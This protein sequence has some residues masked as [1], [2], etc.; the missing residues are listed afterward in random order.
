[1]RRLGLVSA[2]CACA[3]LQSATAHA[4][5]VELAPDDAPPEQKAF[6]A[7]LDK[8]QWVDGPSTVQLTGNASLQVPEGYVF[9]NPKDT[10]RYLEL[11]QNMGDGDEVLVA[12]A[13]LAWS[14]YLSY[15]DEGYVKDDEE[16]DA[17]AL[18]KTLQE[19]T[20]AG[21]EVRRERGWEE[22]HV[23]G[24]A[25]PPAYNT[26]T[27]RLE[28]AT[29]TRS[30]NGEGVNFFTKI[31]GRK[32]HTS[33]QLVTGPETLAEDQALLDG[34][35]GGFEYD[36]GDRYADFR[37]GDKV[38]EY[39]LAAMVVG[40]AAAVAT[41]KGLWPV[42]GLFIAKTWKL[43]AVAAVAV[44]AGARKFLGKKEA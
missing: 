16:I 15:L 37:P 24:W 18:L 29:A 10:L 21:N 42:I 30:D 32:G 19:A 44:V 3:M 4:R 12:P 43:L 39:G 2:L 34:V 17:D 27:K 26:S 40:G 14:A 5:W 20:E 38:A 22:L 6:L 8:L 25:T 11:N 9:L 41:K 1:M 23:T 36:T 33:V 7:E 35:L 13:D 31:L 28:W